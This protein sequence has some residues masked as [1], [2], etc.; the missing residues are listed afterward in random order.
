[1]AP[2]VTF[3]PVG[4]GDM[5]LIELE[6]G[7]KILVDVNV[8]A[9]AD[10]PDD[11]TFDVMSALRDRLSR[12]SEGRLYVDAFLLSHPDQDHCRGLEK[13]FHLGPLESWS[14]SADKVVFREIWSSPIV[15]RRKS[16]NHTL[17]EDASAF[18]AEARRRVKVFRDQGY[19]DSGDRIQ[20]LGEDQDGK[21]DDLTAILVKIDEDV[22]KV[23]G[24]TDDTFSA[25][26]L[27]PLPIQDEEDE[28]ELLAKNESST[29]LR[30]S[31]SKNGTAD[32]CKFLTGG[33]AAVVIWERLWGRHSG[34]P[35][36]LEYDLLQ[37]PHH[38]SWRTLSHDSWSECGEDA[39][40]SEDARSALSQTR[41]GAE[42]IASSKVIEDD[43]N[44]PPC[45]RAKREYEAIAKDCGGTFRCTSGT[46]ARPKNDVTEFEVTEN[47]PS[48]RA[49]Q[50]AAA[51]VVG[52][53]AV[54]RQPLQHGRG[55]KW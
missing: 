30:F 48:Y 18:N 40:V 19:A 24:V 34:N 12:D 14:K 13:H 16:K 49:G 51:A 20:I 9:A 26:L 45:I 41:D 1:M 6:S 7:R 27:G 38:C 11:D 31:I 4:N 55:T 25:R 44:D 39:E 53:G 35:E 32:A 2:T 22:T 17:C 33:D 10:D 37:T 5:T 3:F 52:S 23:D 29:I 21:T 43:D 47:G 50:L 42:L 28:E 36:P 54:G 46:K 8:R 15:F